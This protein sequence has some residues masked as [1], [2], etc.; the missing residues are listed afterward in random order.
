MKRLLFLLI[1]FIMFFQSCKNVKTNDN[2]IIGDTVVL[3]KKNNLNNNILLENNEFSNYLKSFSYATLPV[4]IKGCSI[5]VDK[6]VEF[7]ANESRKFNKDYSYAY[8]RIP[9]NGNYIAAITL[10]VADCYLPVLRTYTLKGEIIDEKVLS[11]G[12]GEIDCGEH[13]EDYMILE[14]DYKI[15]ISDT[16]NS[17]EC[18][19]SFNVI[20]ETCK[21]Y[22]IF[23]KGSLLP[24]GK[25]EL[26]KEIRKNLKKETIH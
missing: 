17:C 1:I 16:I 20:K 6:L 14:K 23:K 13:T 8:C 11:I 18:D 4:V 5:N 2:A 7:Q 22:V 26:T 3:N 21:Q 24:D 15:Y 19:S 12:Y 25:I 10:G 9:T